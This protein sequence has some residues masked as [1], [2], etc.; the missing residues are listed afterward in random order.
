MCL[1]MQFLSV[2]TLEIRV[3]FIVIM[4]EKIDT[5]FMAK[6]KLLLQ[7]CNSFVF[8]VVHI[9]LTAKF[10]LTLF[11]FY[12]GMLHHLQL[13]PVLIIIVMNTKKYT[14]RTETSSSSNISSRE[15]A[16]RFGPVECHS[17]INFDTK[18]WLLSQQMLLRVLI[19]TDK[20][21]STSTFTYI[22]TVHMDKLNDPYKSESFMQQ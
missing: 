19:L 1:E 4:L 15:L 6:W 22:Y 13:M 12:Y 11:G 3:R 8:S 7:N 21:S 2:M 20:L 17:F 14:K 16:F 9:V 18:W 10:S 5:D